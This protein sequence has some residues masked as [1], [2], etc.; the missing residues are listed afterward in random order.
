VPLRSVDALNRK[1][2]SVHCHE[3][4][5]HDCGYQ[6]IMALRTEVAIITNPAKKKGTG[7]GNRRTFKPKR[8]NTWGDRVDT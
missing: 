4:E 1:K 5:E 3:N 8:A 2:C 6:A 7:D